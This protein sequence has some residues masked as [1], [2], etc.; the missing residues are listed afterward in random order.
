MRQLSDGSEAAAP[1]RS[2]ADPLYTRLRSEDTFRRCIP[3]PPVTIPHGLHNILAIL[4][5][6]MAIIIDFRPQGGPSKSRKIEGP[7][8]GNKRHRESYLVEIRA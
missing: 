4:D 2:P 8:R 6:F 5:P 1:T 3:G 7:R